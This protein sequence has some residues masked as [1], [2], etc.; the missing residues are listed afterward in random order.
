MCGCAARH[1][2]SLSSIKTDGSDDRFLDHAHDGQIVFGHNLLTTLSLLL[3][4]II[5]PANAVHPYFV[6]NPHLL[7]SCQFIA[8]ENRITSP[9]HDLIPGASYFFV[10]GPWYMSRSPQSSP[11]GGF[12][13][14]IIPILFATTVPPATFCHVPSRALNHC[15]WYTLFNRAPRI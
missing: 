13:K 3:E 2:S 12:G 8:H 9:C 15:A 7:L 6:M 4:E 10:T 11:V 5:L 14:V 1:N